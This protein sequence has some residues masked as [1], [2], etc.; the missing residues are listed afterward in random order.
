MKDME[1][2]LVLRLCC[3]CTYGNDCMIASCRR[4]IQETC[5]SC[6]AFSP[7]IFV[8]V[9]VVDSFGRSVTYLV[10]CEVGT[11][12]NR[13]ICLDARDAQLIRARL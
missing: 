4:S 3:N 13:L 1:V 5:C 7:L 9:S 8:D 2:L 10:F 11:V 12:I 6:F